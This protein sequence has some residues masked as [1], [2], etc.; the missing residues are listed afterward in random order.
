MQLRPLGRTRLSVSSIGLGCVTFGREIDQGTS[1][2]ILDH[3]VDRG[4]NLL[5]TAA[6]YGEGASETVIGN[7]LEQRGSRGKVVIASK[8]TGDLSPVAI[9]ESINGSLA[10]LKVDTIDLLQFHSW[11]AQ[12]PVEES[13]SA[14]GD[15]MAAGRVR[16]V[17]CSN[18]SAWQV[19][20]AL[21]HSAET[22]APPIESVQPM[23]SLVH[24]EIETD[25]LPLCIDQHVGV[26][27][28]S[29]LGAGFLT[30]KYAKDG[31]LPPG[32][33]FDIKPGHQRFYF[34]DAGW[35]IMEG[36]RAKAAELDTT[37]I[38][39]ALGWVLAQEGVTSMLIGA[40]KVQHV[41][42]ALEADQHPLSEELIA[43]LEGL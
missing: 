28:Y 14:L 9:H 26:M 34:T 41:D 40:R 5:D 39:L 11:D 6:V 16:Y 27:T 3:A 4:I 31:P 19:A 37:M 36:L 10:R 7:W 35:R 1:F 22:G 12:T 42:Q 8:V 21:I 13:L 25:L 20:K 17:G 15:E 24:R 29:P 18:W 2:D 43:E 23:Y 32:T 30:G 38:R 33:R